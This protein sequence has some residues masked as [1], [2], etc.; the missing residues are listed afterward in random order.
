[1]VFAFH[2]EEL[3]SQD[4]AQMVVPGIFRRVNKTL[5]ALLQTIAIICFIHYIAKVSYHSKSFTPCNC[6]NYILL[7]Y[8]IITVFSFLFFFFFFKEEKV[9]DS[10]TPTVSFPLCVG[11]VEV[12]YVNDLYAFLGIT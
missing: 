10:L 8:H 5:P 12:S 7:I 3:S 11:L 4:P 2:F 1:M 9:F 6:R